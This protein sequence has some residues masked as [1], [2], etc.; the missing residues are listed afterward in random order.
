MFDDEGNS[1]PMFSFF[2]QNKE[3]RFIKDQEFKFQEGPFPNKIDIENKI[4]TFGS[5]IFKLKKSKWQEIN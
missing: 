1:G 3:N 5:L 2:F 4:L